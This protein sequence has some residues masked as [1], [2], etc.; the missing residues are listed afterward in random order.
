MSFSVRTQAET[1]LQ[2]AQLARG[3]D[4]GMGQTHIC[5][6]GIH[7]RSAERQPPMSRQALRSPHAL[8][9][10]PSI[11]MKGRNYTTSSIS[12]KGCTDLRSAGEENWGTT[13]VYVA[14]GI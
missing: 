8:L 5:N 10:K 13:R 3:L 7:T 1:A 12:S 4:H 14:A 9:A 6:P 11:R 2:F